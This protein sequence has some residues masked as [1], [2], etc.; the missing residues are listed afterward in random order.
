MELKELIYPTCSDIRNA[1]EGST[2]TCQHP[3]ILIGV[4]SIIALILFLVLKEHKHQ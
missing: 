2:T 3:W 4:L 1:I